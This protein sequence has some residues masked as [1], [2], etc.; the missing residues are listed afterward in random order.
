MEKSKIQ[1]NPDEKMQVERDGKVIECDVL[2]SF[3]SDD[4]L[5]TYVGYTDHSFSPDGRKNVY[6]SS[7]DPF[8]DSL[9]LDDITDPREIDM[10]RNVLE[11]IDQEANS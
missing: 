1:I 3:V 10:V 7:L 5:K 11:Q 9:K 4:T 8:S 2:F 6:V